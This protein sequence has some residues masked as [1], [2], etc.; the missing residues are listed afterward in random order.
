[1]GTASLTAELENLV[2]IRRFV[3]NTAQSLQ[4][5]QAAIDDVIQAVDEVAT[6]I[7]VHGYAAKPGI[8]DVEVKREGAALI[9]HLLDQAPQF[10]PT[11]VPP[12]DLTLPLEK[13]QPGGLGI[14]LIREY[15]DQVRYLAIPQGCNELTLLKKHFERRSYLLKVVGLLFMPWLTRKSALREIKVAQSAAQGKPDAGNL[16]Y[17]RVF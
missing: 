5:D 2:L 6:N 1:V 4:A 17:G 7:I 8:I 12:P 16:G 10:D 13:R 15:M 14:H 11:A 9:V 3:E